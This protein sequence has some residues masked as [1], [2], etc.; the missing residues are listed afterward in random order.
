M[1]TT[2]QFQNKPDYYLKIDECIA[3]KKINLVSNPR[4][5]NFTQTHFTAGDE[6]QFQKYRD[7]SNG[8]VCMPKISLEKNIFDST[9]FIDIK[10]DKYKNL[11]AISVNNTFKYM[12]NKLKKGIFVKIK[13]NQV[14]VF[15]PFSKKTFINEWGNR[16]KIDPRYGDMFG[17]IKYISTLQGRKFLPK[18]INKFTDTWY[19]NN[20]LLRYEF[21]IGE[22]D[23][24]VSQ[25]S[26]MLKTLCANRKVPDIEF[27]I[28]RRD[29]PIIKRNSTEPYN[30]LFGTNHPLIS[31]NY[32]NYSPILSMVTTTQFADI[33]IPTGDDWTRIGRNE[34]KF[35]PRGCQSV[36]NDFNIEWKNKKPTAVFRGS[37]T[38][39]GVTIETNM[40]LKASYL[41]LKTPPEKNIPL[42]DAGITKWNLRPRKLEGYK[43]LETI[44]LNKLNKLGIKTANMLTP[45]QQS[46]Y[47]YV[48]NIDGHVAAFRLSLEMSM[49]S[50]LL[51]VDSQYKIWF[52]N[53][54]FPYVHYV[55]V[56]YD[57]SNL[58]TQIRW[59]RDND[60]KCELIAKNSKQFFDKYLQKDGC[61]DYLQKLL[62]DL[63]KENGIYLYN[64]ITPLKLQIQGEHKNINKKNLTQLKNKI[65]KI[66][67]QKRSYGLL[68]GIELTVSKATTQFEDITIKGDILFENT[69]KT[70][71]IQRYLFADFPMCVKK[72]VDKS[73][74]QQ[75]IH[76]TFVG[77]NCINEL[78]KYSPNFAY[79]FGSYSTFEN[80]NNVI[81]EYIRGQTLSNWIRNDF[82]MKN[83]IFILLQI[84]MSLEIAQNKYGFVH[85]DLTPWNICIKKKDTIEYFDYIL[86]H[87]TIYRVHTNIIPIIID[88][89]TSHVIYK[90]KHHGY[91]NIYKTST[92]QDLLSLLTTSIY[93]ITNL[94][95]LSRQDTFEL[96]KLSNFLTGNEYYRRPFV[97]SGK[98][99]LGGIRYFFNKDK[100]FNNLVYSEKYDLENKTPIDFISYIKQNF[101]Y[102]FTYD[103]VNSVKYSLNMG[104]PRQVSN[105]IYANSLDD[106]LKTFTTFFERIGECTLPISSNI[107]YIYFAAQT[108]V[109]NIE[110]VNFIMNQ[111]ITEENIIFPQGQQLY[112]KTIS[113][114]KNKYTKLLEQKGKEI[115]Y[116]LEKKYKYDHLVH[117]PY[118]VETFLLPNII[119]NLLTS[120]KDGLNGE[121]LSDYKDMFCYILINKGPFQLSEVHKKFYLKNF[122]LLL[123]TKDINIKNNLANIVTLFYVSDNLYSKDLFH[124]E[125]NILKQ[126]C[127]GNNEYLDIYKSIKN[128]LN[129]QAQIL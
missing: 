86:D 84:A 26:D 116:N 47:K 50:C 100:K 25:M 89:G 7:A 45:L 124:L 38:G 78:I 126:K 56:K 23:T 76:E 35:F 83:Y 121:D 20:C 2:S 94:K 6:E 68:K 3:S 113:Y 1:T 42:L 71:I 101:S 128:I 87:K 108:L 80:K 93:E 75:N 127:L 102:K 36:I 125:K 11:D 18:Y 40:R 82:N 60:E 33:P 22:G 51:L 9:N 95:T 5:K 34:N 17:F 12:F 4:Y 29:F 129:Q 14:R 70:T 120:Y 85:Y 115:V 32:K 49:G 81:T 65:Y 28:N 19:A 67:N 62:I 69:N 52:R 64:S 99:G 96:I 104:N 103:K 66:P 91:V 53:M 73:K 92:I 37:S 55:P 118:S 74:Q 123:E 59:C 27:F 16:I 43:Y 44:D 57:L 88:Y 15:L 90:N 107:F 119:Y 98:N 46:E 10:W 111:F 79:I 24:N 106:K 54:L 13:D 61:L 21:P 31:H 97:Y 8:Q 30:H 122:K 110:S 58:I 112:K 114:L 48:L 109:E 63:K 39:C 41:S 117:A 105:Y 77:L 72:S